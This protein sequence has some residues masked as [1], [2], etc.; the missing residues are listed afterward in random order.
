VNS[1]DDFVRS[2]AYRRIFPADA[3]T[4]ASRI[5][6]QMLPFCTRELREVDGDPQAERKCVI[7][8]RTENLELVRGRSLLRRQMHRS[9]APKPV[10]AESCS[11]ESRER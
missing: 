6:V 8:S 1:G 5:R 10:V 3:P 4:A 2:P 7:R 11:T 9:A